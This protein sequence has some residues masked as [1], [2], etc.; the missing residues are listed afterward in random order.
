MGEGGAICKLR[1]KGLWRLPFISSMSL[2]FPSSISPP[3]SWDLVC[4]G[5]AQSFAT[6]D[7]W[8]DWV[9]QLVLGLLASTSW[10][11]EPFRQSVKEPRRVQI[12][13]WWLSIHL[14]GFLPCWSS[15][16]L[17]LLV[18][19]TQTRAK[20]SQPGFWSLSANVSLQR[21]CSQS[22]LHLK[23]NVKLFHLYIGSYDISLLHSLIFWSFLAGEQR[24]W[25]GFGEDV[26]TQGWAWQ[27]FC[28]RVKS[29]AGRE[30]TR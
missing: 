19:G 22:V 24:R 25:P 3:L 21:A 11:W 18:C 1:Q 7:C 2:E 29:I 27:R 30:G 28:S 6:V 17:A 5:A 16:D 26:E 20:I 14:V 9:F 10:L 23:V 4:H 12:F 13:R 8:I 15:S